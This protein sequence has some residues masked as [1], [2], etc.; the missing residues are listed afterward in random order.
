[1]K[2]QTIAAAVGAALI[3]GAGWAVNGW[4]LG[5]NI[6]QIQLAHTEELAA[7]DAGTFA[8]AQAIDTNY[9]RL[10]NASIQ[11]QARLAGAAAVATRNAGRLREQLQQADV[12]IATASA[13]AVREYAATANQLLE[14]SSQ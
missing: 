14:Q 10:L 8:V 9:Q 5:Q 6:A 4:R 12:R 13:A 3:F 7:R 1:M 11:E 2:V